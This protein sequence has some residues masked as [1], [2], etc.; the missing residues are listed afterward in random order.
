MKQ[1]EPVRELIALIRRHRLTYD[2]FRVACYNARKSLSLKPPHRR[3]HLAKLL[4]APQLTA[5]YAA[6]DNTDNLQHQVMLRLLLHTAIRVSEL[7]AIK[8]SDI[9]LDSSKI[10][11]ESGKGDK[12]RYVLMPDSFRMVL[13]AYLA[14]IPDNTYLFESRQRRAFSRRMINYIVT[15]YAKDAGIEA[16]VHPHLFRHQMLTHLTK[17]GLSSSQIQLISGHSSSKSLEH[18]QHLALNDVSGDYQRA[19]K[20]LEV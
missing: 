8:V 2:S 9:D 16:G 11:I 19:A 17:E 7:T 3:R 10:F 6:V 15:D 14:T 13:R 18:Y 5:F 20:K 4:T 1:S 12:D